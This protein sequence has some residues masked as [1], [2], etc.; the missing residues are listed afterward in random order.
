[1]TYKERY[2]PDIPF[3][4]YMEL[5]IKDSYSLEE[6]YIYSQE[7][8][9]VH[10]FYIH[11][12]LDFDCNFGT[13]VYA[14]ASG[15]AVAGYHRF[16]LFN[17]DRTLRLHEGKPLGFGFGNMVQIYHSEETSGVLGGRVTQYGHLSSVSSSI[18]MKLFP[19]EEGD[20]I[21]RIGEYYQRHPRYDID[22]Q[23]IMAA[24]KNLVDRYP[25]VGSRYGFRNNVDPHMKESYML[26]YEEVQQLYAENDPYVVWVEQGEQ[27]GTVGNSAVIWG[28]LTYEENSEAAN[29][30]I[31]ATPP[32]WDGDHLH[33]EEAARNQRGQKIQRRDPFDIYKSR[34]WYKKK[35]IQRSLFRD[36]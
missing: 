30:G 8:R 26:T 21:Y 28:D 22:L 6:G 4:P 20:I 11:G 36:Y 16:T 33:F 35:Y 23:E 31:V 2:S 25:W 19:A 15:F 27:I 34:K 17:E 7:E 24:H 13:P 3:V 18:K 9:D 10:G 5:P 32:A 1:M 29:Q 12:G 14:A